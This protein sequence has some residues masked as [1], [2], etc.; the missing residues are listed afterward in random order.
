MVRPSPAGTQTTCKQVH[1]KEGPEVSPPKREPKCSFCREETHPYQACQVLKQMNIEE[2]DELMRQQVAEYENSQGEAIRHAIL[3]EYGPA[4]LVSD[5]TSSWKGSSTLPHP[6]EGGTRQVG[7]MGKGQT[8]EGPNWWS[9]LR[10]P[11]D[12]RPSQPQEEGIGDTQ[13]TGSKPNQLPRYQTPF[14]TSTPYITGGYLYQGTSIG[15][16]GGPPGG[17]D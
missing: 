8:P 5:P 15:P 10:D 12:N 4:T 2:A 17:G 7:P 6:S 1:I 13:G 16:S 11:Q 14:T 9:Q 3:E